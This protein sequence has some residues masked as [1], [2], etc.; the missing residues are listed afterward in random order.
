MAD[1]IR[2]GFEEVSVEIIEGSGGVFDVT[3][4]GVLIYSKKDT[5]RFPERGEVVSSMKG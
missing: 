2:E 5:G 1:E 4:D 3:V